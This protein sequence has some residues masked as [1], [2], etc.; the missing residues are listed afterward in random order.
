LTILHFHE[1]GL[2]NKQLEVVKQKSDLRVDVG[3]PFGFSRNYCIA[4]VLKIPESIDGIGIDNLPLKLLK[5]IEGGFI[6]TIGLS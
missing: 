2:S 5:L 1:L 4:A 3:F 6:T